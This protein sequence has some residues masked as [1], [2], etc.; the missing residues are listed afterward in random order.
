MTTFRDRADEPEVQAELELA[1]VEL[2]QAVDLKTW[3]AVDWQA[4]DLLSSLTGDSWAF[5]EQT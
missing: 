2:A 5:L 4:L 1:L 3:Q